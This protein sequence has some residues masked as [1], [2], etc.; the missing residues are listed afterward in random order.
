M[1]KEPPERGARHPLLLYQR[2]NEQVFWPCILIMVICA[3]LLVWA[4]DRLPGQRLKLAVALV[5]SGAILALTYAYRLTA[6]PDHPLRSHP[7][8]PAHRLFPALSAQKS[9]PPAAQLPVAHHGQ[10]GHSARAR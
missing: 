6:S 1:P 9:A 8:H 5:G 3:L 4:P 2:W 10:H 7:D